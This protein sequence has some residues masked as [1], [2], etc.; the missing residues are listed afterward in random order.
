MSTHTH[1]LL[2]TTVTAT[3]CHAAFTVL[4]TGVPALGHCADTMSP[5]VMLDPLIC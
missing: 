3:V 2:T 5:S 4:F 1:T